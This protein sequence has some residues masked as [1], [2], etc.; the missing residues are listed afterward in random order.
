MTRRVHMTPIGAVAPGMVLADA[1]CEPG[2]AVLLPAGATLTGAMLNALR[3]RGIASLDVLVADGAGD[4]A[5][6][7]AEA[8]SEAER[9]CARL[10]R[11]FRNSATQGA[12]GLLLARLLHYR[13]TG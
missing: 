8:E 9:Q 1:L 6:G 7:A 10:E 4:T 12:T 2:G 13:R 11:M 5:G 3:R